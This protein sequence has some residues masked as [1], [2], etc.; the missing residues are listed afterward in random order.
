M[1]D[2]DEKLT[3]GQKEIPEPGQVQRA[4]EIG[5]GQ[6]LKGWLEATGKKQGKLA[7]ALHVSDSVMSRWI[8]GKRPLDT[9]VVVKILLRF[10]KWLGEDWEVADALDGILWIGLGWEDVAASL[11]E[12]FQ[13]DGTLRS[14]R[15]W[16]SCT[17]SSFASNSKS[18]LSSGWSENL[19][20]SCL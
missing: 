2:Q 20:A 11:E 6:I 9:P 3:G 17:T 14:F 18:S 19:P 16:C 13:R 15:N 4:G 1:P 8:T 10:H 12:D 5:F 7:Q